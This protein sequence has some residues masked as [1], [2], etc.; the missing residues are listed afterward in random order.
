MA[1]SG[2]YIRL[3]VTISDTNGAETEF[4]SNALPFVDS[5]ASGTL[6]ISG[7]YKVGETITFNATSI[8]D[9]DVITNTS[10]QWQYSNDNSGY[11]DISGE[12][13][14]TF[15]IITTTASFIGTYIRLKVIIT[16]TN[17]AETEFVS[18]ALEFQDTVATG[19]VDISGTYKVGETITSDATSIADADVITSTSYQWQYS[20]DNSG[21]SDFS[22]ETGEELIIISTTA[23]SGIYIR[24]KV[25]ITDTN[26]V[27][28]EFV[29][30]ELSFVD[31]DASGTLDISGEYTVSRTLTAYTDGISDVDG[32]LEFQ[33]QWY[34]SND[35]EASYNSIED[36]S[37]VSIENATDESLVLIE[38]YIGKYIKLVVDGQ[39]P[40]GY[41]YTFEKK[42]T[43]TVNDIT[44]YK[45]RLIIDADGALIDAYLSLIHI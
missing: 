36:V 12:T 35:V 30:N 14:T 45:A 5:A 31:T 15:N 37:Y 42:S 43:T 17:G 10:Y 27:D 20:N 40:N 23:S 6:D 4:V 41:A 8:V 21:Y 19:T 39:D 38:D 7:T 26:G 34:V 13:G 16:D 22:D 3:K 33:Y 2:T 9:V 28:I 25:T 1:S 24:L 29:S 44:Q 32:E 18:S 11:S